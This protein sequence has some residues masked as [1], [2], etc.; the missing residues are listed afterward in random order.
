MFD[1]A[2]MTKTDSGEILKKTAFVNLTQY[3]AEKIAHR[4]NRLNILAAKQT[5]KVFKYVFTVVKNG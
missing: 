3:D 1:I 5:G 4:L 2:L